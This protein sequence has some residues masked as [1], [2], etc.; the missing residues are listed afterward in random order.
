MC[1]KVIINFFEC[2]RDHF[3]KYSIRENKIWS[4]YGKQYP[5]ILSF[6]VGNC[7]LEAG[8]TVITSAGSFSGCCT[9]ELMMAWTKDRFSLEILSYTFGSCDW[10][11]YII[12]LK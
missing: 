1:T 8:A 7:T 9:D 6:K 2:L 3:L 10:A 5:C 4:Q 12:N 11:S